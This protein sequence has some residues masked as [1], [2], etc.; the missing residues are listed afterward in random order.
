MSLSK[1]IE[2]SFARSSKK[3]D[4][5]DQSKEG[6]TGDEPKKISEENSGI[7]SLSEMWDHFLRER[8]FKIS[9]ICRNSF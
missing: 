3:R 4:L 8:E 1:D 6:K 5:S 7:E 9:C 2:K